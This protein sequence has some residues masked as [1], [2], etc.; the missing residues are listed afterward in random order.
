MKKF[1]SVFI[2][3]IC[4]NLCAVLSFSSWASERAQFKKLKELGTK[5]VKFVNQKFDKLFKEKPELKRYI[6]QPSKRNLLEGI[7]KRKLGPGP[8][9]LYVLA[10]RIEFQEDTTSLTTGNGLMDIEGNEFPYDSLGYINGKRDSPFDSIS[11]NKGYH[12][13]YYDPPHTKRYFEH[14]M[15]SLRNY[16]WDNSGGKLYIK[17]DVV[18][19]GDNA[20]YKLPYKMTY[21]GDPEN[22]VQGLLTLFRDAVLTC[23]EDTLVKFKNYDAVILFHAGSMWQTDY[24]WDSPCDIIACF[25]ANI[26]EYFGTPVWVDD[27]TVAITEGIIYP[28]TAFQDGMS[29]YLQGGL[30]HEFGHQLGLYDL[31]DTWGETMGC[32]GWALMGTGNWNL[33]GLLPPHTSAWHTEKLGWI[34]PEI[35][36]KDTTDIKVYRMGG[37][38]TTRTKLYKVPINTK[39]YFLV[40]E[41]FAYHSPDTSVDSFWVSPDSIF[42]FDSTGIRVWKDGVLI[43]FDDYD[44]GT[45]CDT[46]AGGLAIWHIDEDKVARDSLMNEINVGSPKGVDMEEA[47]GIQD[48]ET[49]W[50]L[51]TN[52]EAF[53]YGTP[54]DVF[55]EG[56]LDKFTPITKPNTNNNK[57]SMSHI[58]IYNISKSDTVMS[59]SLKFDWRYASFPVKCG[60][61]FDVNSPN[62]IEVNGK[63]LIACNVMDT[64]NGGYTFVCND[65]GGI[66]W[67]YQPVDAGYGANIF[68]SPAIG[69]IN[70]DGIPDVVCGA[71]FGRWR[72]SKKTF[73]S[74]RLKPSATSSFKM[75]KDSV[76]EVWSKVYAW[77]ILSGNILPGFPTTDTI[78]DAIISA[79]LL[80]NIDTIE[81]K[82]IFIGSDDGKLYAWDGNGNSLAGFPKNLHQYIWTTPVY[83]SCDTVIYAVSFD[84]RIWAIKPNGDT[85]WTAL[86]PHLPP[87]TSS[88]VVGDINGDGKSEIIISTG[89]GEVYCINNSGKTIWSR[90]LKDTSFYSSPALADIDGDSLL[91]II[92]AAGNKIYA[93]NNNG[94]NLPGFPIETKVSESFQSSPVVGDINGD[95]R[96]EIVIGSPDGEL[97]AYT[98][99]GDL[100][101][102]F[103]LSVGGKIYSTPVLVDIDG[104]ELLEI[105]VGC[106]DGK[107]YAWSLGNYGALPWAMLHCDEC[108]NGIYKLT[109]T[110]PIIP[111]NV[112]KES[113]FYIYP[114]PVHS[115][116]RIKYFSGSASS[117]N[118]KIINIAG[119]IVKDFEGKI[120]EKGSIE[121]PLPDLVS[122]I[123]IC[124]IEVK[125]GSENF[126][127]FKKFAVVK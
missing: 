71:Y 96:L 10:I 101:S 45:P 36:D 4:V 31:Y 122:G 3:L 46:M 103:P 75:A 33:N 38:D 111:T 63:K 76:L 67:S 127:R 18:P 53:F 44:W 54:W 27:G 81:G 64:L 24:F 60:D 117:V 90:S 20:S 65:S 17:F 30:A 79:P 25:V 105:I 94:A 7:K 49:P 92:L 70:G 12:N 52:M 15:E 37:N 78:R 77:D 83:D 48:F 43:R 87:T 8:D 114:N 68:S 95:G 29:G 35:L 118:I 119:E 34:K 112:F 109:P 100:A 104:D 110:P 93:F 98:N 89:I 42:H 99:K 125:A 86:E 51:A 84:G 102:G 57:G 123:Y 113:P 19:D 120:G 6:R 22:Y 74:R 69:D 40:T 16:W 91:D 55:Y 14:L 62:I 107:L 106:D 11:G 58:S 116:G 73:Y 50:W 47:D 2:F 1:K 41:R 82:E 39:E 80:A 126:V 88:P 97:L 124:R 5:R 115:W 72:E 56:N 32:G 9:T 61:F 59:F 13:L 85:L 121:V 26:D 28:E 108:N 66:K 21:Y 23:D